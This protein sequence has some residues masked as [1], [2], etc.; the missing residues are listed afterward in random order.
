MDGVS[1]ISRIRDHLFYNWKRRIVPVR[2]DN[3][4]QRRAAT[5]LGGDFRIEHMKSNDFGHAGAL[6]HLIS[7]HS[8][9]DEEIVGGAHP[10]RVRHGGSDRPIC[11]DLR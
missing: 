1:H 11:G 3:R 4:L 5:L 10:S 2:S 9:P 6:S 8:A 7:S